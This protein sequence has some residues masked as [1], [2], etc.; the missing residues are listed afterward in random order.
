MDF[1][2]VLRPLGIGQ[3]RDGLPKIEPIGVTRIASDA[4]GVIFP[5]IQRALIECVNAIDA[6]GA[7]RDDVVRRQPTEFIFEVGIDVAV[8][9]RRCR[10][11][12]LLPTHETVNI[13]ISLEEVSPR[14]DRRI[15][16]GAGITVRM[17]QPQAVT[18]FMR[19]SREIVEAD[20]RSTAVRRGA[21]LS[22]NGARGDDIY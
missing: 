11:A 8:R 15:I 9:R 7:G 5:R 14:F 13:A 10:A 18:Q 6:R 22:R 4:H 3:I 1:Q 16:R 17:L 20:D 21:G 12:V 2:P 19:Q